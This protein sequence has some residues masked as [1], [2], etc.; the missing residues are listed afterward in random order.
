MAGKA[1]IEARTAALA[2]QLKQGLAAIPGVIVNTPMA[3]EL[4]AGIVSFDVDGRSSDTVVQALRDR[5]IIGSVAPY[6]VPHARLTPSIRNFPEEIEFALR[7]MQEIA[8]A[9]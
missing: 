7:A 1:A 8:S 9:P 3:P 2:T 6:R 4:S 5:Y